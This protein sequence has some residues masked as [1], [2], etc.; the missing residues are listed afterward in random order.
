M[1]VSSWW[2]LDFVLLDG[3]FL[4]YCFVLCFDL[5]KKDCLG[6]VLCLAIELGIPQA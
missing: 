1:V 4:L 5:S 6:L 3:G 2:F